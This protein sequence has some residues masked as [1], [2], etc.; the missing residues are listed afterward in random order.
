MKITNFVAGLALMTATSAAAETRFKNGVT[1][2]GYIELGQVHT[3]SS[4][5]ADYNHSLLRADIDLSFKPAPT[6][7]GLSLGIDGYGGSIAQDVALH[8]ALE[9]SASLGTV[10]IG[11]PRSV[12][13][14]GY[15]PTFT[16][17]NSSFAD[18]EYFAFSRSAVSQFNMSN[19][20]IPYGIRYDGAIGQTKI[21]FSAHKLN[22]D[23][24]P[25][26][27]YSL[28]LS[29]HLDTN[30]LLGSLHLSAARERFS[31]ENGYY[32]TAHH[33]GIEA[34][35]GRT[36]LGLLYKEDGIVFHYETLVAYVQH[37]LRDTLTLTASF[38]R[39]DN[40][41][42]SLLSFLSAYN[43]YGVGLEYTLKSNAYLKASI[44]DASINPNGPSAELMMGWKF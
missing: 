33:I 35:N 4:D 34:V 16:I 32:H 25:G 7:F 30:T 27:S 39:I 38:G 18:M 14:R 2:D 13:D 15:L 11:A 43:Y 6:G 26:N 36:T 37:N 10:S 21:G 42:S 31:L 1:I 12:V 9:Y 8:P 3:L 28:A 29:R 20:N 5:N 41:Y 23:S 40:P 24:S 17:G 19:S 22:N 44:T